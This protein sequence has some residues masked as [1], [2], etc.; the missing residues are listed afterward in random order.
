LS[1]SAALTWIRAPRG[2]SR[3][4]KARAARLVRFAELKMEPVVGLVVG[5]VEI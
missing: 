3:L 5:I 2:V 1:L 4:T